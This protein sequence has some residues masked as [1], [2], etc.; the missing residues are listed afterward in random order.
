MVLG[1]QHFDAWLDCKATE[2]KAAQELLWPH[3]DDL[4]DAIEMHLKHSRRDEPWIQEPLQTQLLIVSDFSTY[5]SLPGLRMPFGSKACLIFR[6]I[7]S[8]RG[9]LA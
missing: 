8:S 7:S 2:V 3:S 6:I 4:F 9:C 5:S 1:Q